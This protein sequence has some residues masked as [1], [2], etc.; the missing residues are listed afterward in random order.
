MPRIDIKTTIGF[1]PRK[2]A[3]EITYITRGATAS[4][5][6]MLM[7]KMY[8]FEDITQMTF[9]FRQG[10]DMWWYNLI[11]YFIPS[12]DEEIDYTKVYY[13]VNIPNPDISYECVAVEIIDPKFIPKGNYYEKVANP[14]DNTETAPWRR[15]EHFSWPDNYEFI[16]FMLFPENT[17]EFNLTTPDDNIVFEIAI[18]LNTDVRFGAQARDSVLI[19]PQHPVAVID[20]VF[21]R[22]DDSEVEGSGYFNQKAIPSI[23]TLCANQL[24]C[25]KYR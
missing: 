19:E 23:I 3:H 22:I 2:R 16:N 11:E 4:F 15:N 14:G 10:K 20:S 1:C 8:S 25:N 7:D 5:T 9:S 18:K 6:F 24:L 12:E 21:S 13:E 17:R